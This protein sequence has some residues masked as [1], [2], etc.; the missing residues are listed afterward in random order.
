MS[1]P[2]K[3]IP[4]SDEVLQE[5]GWDRARI[6]PHAGETGPFAPVKMADAICGHCGNPTIGWTVINLATASAIGS[7]W[8]H[9]EAEEKADEKA[10]E[11]NRAWLLGFEAATP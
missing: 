7:E 9:A 10:S 8:T 5:N 11:L 1:D 6:F 2:L 4:A 3:F